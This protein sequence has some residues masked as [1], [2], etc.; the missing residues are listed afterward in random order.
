MESA[1]YNTF[2]DNVANS[3][4]KYGFYF[5]A[6][7]S[8]SDNNTLTNNNANSNTE[9]GIRMNSGT[10]NTLIGNTFNSNV[11]DGI[12][13]KDV[14]TNLTLNNNSFT[15]SQIGIDIA[16]VGMDLASW[17]L[18]NNNISGNST[19]NIVNVSTSTLTAT[20]T[21]WGSSVKA[22][23][24]ASINSSSTVNFL[25]YYISSGM[26]TLSD[27][28]AITGFTIPGQTVSTTIDESTYAIS[29]TMPYGTDVT[30][31]VPTITIT[32][33]SVDPI[34]GTSTDFTSTTIYTVTAIDETIQAYDATVSLA[35][36][37]AKAIT[38]FTIP[39]QVGSTTISES[40][41]TI[42][43]VMPNGTNVSALVS[44]F[45]TTGSLVEI[46]EITQIS[47][48][49]SVDLAP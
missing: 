32:G 6:G 26:T 21:W 35:P 2:T 20:S 13:L 41:H 28:K 23:V 7:T 1:D 27:I 38:G 45:I 5:S 37:S 9:Y 14:I 31:L 49:T 47:G 4:A 48:S 10:G 25:P 40:A 8:N 12:R 43:I 11:I 15:N 3:N 19:Y 42:T 22:T 33:A 36:N 18:T 24:E 44:T 17:S 30:S 46:G 16:T 34:S 29:L 39:T